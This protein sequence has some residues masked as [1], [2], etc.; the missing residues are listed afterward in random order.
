MKSDAKLTHYTPNGL[1]FSDG[2]EIPAD[3]VIFATGFDLNIQNQIEKLFGKDIAEQVGPF[4][5]V[6]SEGELQGA[7]K[8]NRKYNLFKK[9]SPA[10]L[11][12]L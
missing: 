11:I 2:S 3:L 5:V 6:D 8:F 9:G 4:S 1:G 7:W 10:S 12:F